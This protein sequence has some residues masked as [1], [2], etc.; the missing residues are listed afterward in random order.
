[1]FKYRIPTI[2]QLVFNK[3]TWKVKTNDKQLFLTFDDGP[4]PTITPWVLAQLKAYEAKATFFCV[5]HNVQKYPE[6]YSH[7]LS[8]GHQTGN[9]TFHH[10]KGWA[11]ENETYFADIE[12]AEE[13]IKSNLFRPPYGRIKPSQADF[14][15]KRFQI[16]MWDLLSCDYEKNLNIS[17]CLNQMKKVKNGSIIVFHDSEKSFENLKQILPHLLDFY[18]SKGY[19]LL[20]IPQK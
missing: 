9:H 6:T 5:G 14:L 11:T 16:I 20:S 8:E 3:Y 4:H 17:F 13:L 18:K 10:L 12:K 1:M 7:I 15:K 2:L 19:Q